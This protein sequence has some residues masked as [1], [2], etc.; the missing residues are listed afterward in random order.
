[1]VRLVNVSDI[2]SDEPDKL[3]KN[4]MTLPKLTITEESEQLKKFDSNGNF[5]YV[6]KD[7]LGTSSSKITVDIKS[8]GLGNSLYGSINSS[9]KKV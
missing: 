9:F 1:M 7:S 5:I 3:D 6:T 4:L 2:Y 8:D